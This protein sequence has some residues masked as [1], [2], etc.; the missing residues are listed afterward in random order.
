MKSVEVRGRCTTD[1]S[2][3]VPLSVPPV[4]AQVPTKPVRGSLLVGTSEPASMC[5]PPVPAAPP[6]LPP[7]PPPGVSP[8]F[9]HLLSVAQAYPLGQ[10][11]PAPQTSL[12]LA[13][14]GE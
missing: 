10:V 1:P 4:K 13:K 11:C 5:A 12:S 9:Q 6:S 7:V 14:S 8:V 3:Q 2:V